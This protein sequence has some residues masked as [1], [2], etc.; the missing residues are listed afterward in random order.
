M[1]LISPRYFECVVS[2]TVVYCEVS[3]LYADIFPNDTCITFDKNHG[4]FKEKLISI[5]LMIRN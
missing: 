1:G 4:D 5:F 2:G 3:S